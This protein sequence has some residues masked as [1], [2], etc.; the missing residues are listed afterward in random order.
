MEVMPVHADPKPDTHDISV[1]TKRVPPPVSKRIKPAIGSEQQV[2]AADQN[3]ATAAGK[4][5]IATGIADL[6]SEESTATASGAREDFPFVTTS[7][8]GSD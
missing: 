6:R 5:N 7:P 3:L 8:Y 2:L 4:V 1:A